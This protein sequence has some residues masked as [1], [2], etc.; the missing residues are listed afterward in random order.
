M[1]AVWETWSEYLEAPKGKV[2]RS[3]K[4]FAWVQ[5]ARA[6]INRALSGE[7]I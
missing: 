7:N 6:S 5:L 2:P 3:R 1:K 4:G